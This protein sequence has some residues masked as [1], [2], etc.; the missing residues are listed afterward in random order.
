MCCRIFRRCHRAFG[1]VRSGLALTALISQC[2]QYRRI[3]QHYDA[4][5]R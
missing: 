5:H 2:H 4:D 1:D 3:Y